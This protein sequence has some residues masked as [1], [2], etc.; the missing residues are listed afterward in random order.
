M[1]FFEIFDPG[2]RF[3]RQQRDLE[4]SLVLTDAQGGDGPQPLDLDSGSVVLRLPSG[5]PATPPADDKDWTFVLNTPCSECG[6]LGS[7][8]ATAELPERVRA[9]TAPW[10]AILARPDVAVRPSATVW[11]ALEYGCHV[12]DVLRIFNRR[13]ELM[14]STDDPLFENWDQDATALEQRYW[15]QDPAVV[16]G[17]LMVAAAENVAEW[18]SVRAEE[19]DRPGRRSNGS[20]FTVAT[21]GQY[22]LHDLVHHLHDVG[23]PVD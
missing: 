23:S 19:W 20:V 5:E 18:T 22:F 9:A 2:Q 21:L 7:A 13:L 11:S 8:V 10:P 3:Q 14:R 15:E 16:S 1:S 4:K 17:E 12:R 6:Y